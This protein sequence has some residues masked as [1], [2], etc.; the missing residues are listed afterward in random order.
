VL[1]AAANRSRVLDGEQSEWNTVIRDRAA[2]LRGPRV[3][4]R[5]QQRTLRVSLAERKGRTADVGEAPQ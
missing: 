1:N 5:D 3:S 2:A 4:V